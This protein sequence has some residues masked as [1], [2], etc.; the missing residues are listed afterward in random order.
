MPLLGTDPAGFILAC[1]CGGCGEERFKPMT[2]G[3]PT[4]DLGAFIWVVLLE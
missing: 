3:S 1:V 4:L 2:S